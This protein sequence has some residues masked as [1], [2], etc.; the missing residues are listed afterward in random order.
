MMQLKWEQEK[1][2]SVILDEVSKFRALFMKLA[3]DKTIVALGLVQVFYE[4]YVLMFSMYWMSLVEM[5]YCFLFQLF[6]QI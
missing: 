5:V 1:E 3:H 6:N 2:V 4:T